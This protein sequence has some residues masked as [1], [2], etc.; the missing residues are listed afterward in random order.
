MS[1][2]G[3]VRRSVAHF[4]LG[5][6]FVTSGARA[7]L[8]G[9]SITDAFNRHA[10]GDFGNVCEEDFDAN[11]DAIAEG[12]HIVSSYRCDNNQGSTSKVYVITEADRSMTTLLLAPEY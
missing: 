4:R 9:Q 1:N 6:W 10:K 11:L 5:R 3:S 12:L 2:S 8:V 7:K